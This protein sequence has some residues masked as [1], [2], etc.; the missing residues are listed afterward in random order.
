[1]MVGATW[2]VPAQA[3]SADAQRNFDIPAQPLPAALALFGRQSGLQVSV[4]AA[5]AE[6]RN[7][8]AVSGS[9]APVQALGRLLAGTG[10]TYR[11]SG[12]IVTLEPAPQR[13]EGT[14]LLDT[15]RVEGAN[16]D[17]GSAGGNHRVAG[18][19]GTAET[20]YVTP[21]SV[22]VVTRETLEAYPAQS[23]A[24]MLRGVTGVIS[25][26]ARTGGSLD[27]N[28]RG[29][30]GQGR[31]PVTVDGA[32]NGTT[33]YRGYQGTSNR[34][35]VDPDFISHIAIEKGPSMGNAIAGG[36]GG[37]VSMTTIAADDIVPEGETMAI[38]VKASLS[39]NS[40]TP[41]SEMTRTVM[42][43][44]AY[45]GD[46]Y[47]ATRGNDRPGVFTPTG[48]AGSLVF[49]SKG[50][51]LDIVAGYSF[52]RTGNYH[53]G[54]SGKYAPQEIGTPSEF[55]A[56][57]PADTQLLEMCQRAVA[58]YDRYGST[59]FVG[60]EE[61]YNTSTDSESVLVKATLRPADDHALELSYGGYWST[62]GENY[63][64]SLG[65]A[66]G[67]VFQTA[68]LS[69]TSLDRLAARYRWNPDS[70]LVDLRLNGWLSKMEEMAPSFGNFDPTRRYVDSWGA[71]LSN[72]SRVG[73]P[74]G[75]FSADYGA[76][77]L[78]EKAGPVEG[79][80]TGGS[81]P[82]GREGTRREIS[83]FT[84]TSLAPTDWLRID[85]GLRYQ[86]YKLQD[87]QTGT[88]YNTALLDRAEDA[89]S[90]SLGGVLTPVDGFQLFAS[91]KQAA[92][93]PSLMEATTGFFMLA[94]PDLHKEE[95]RNWEFGANYLHT[96]L[97]GDNDDLGLKLAWF[98]NDIDG[99]IARR[100]VTSSWAMQMYNIDRARFRGLEG[101][102]HYATG[103]FTMD[104]GATWYERIQFCRDEASGCIESSLASDY[105][106]N[107]IPPRWSAN[108]HVAQ[109]LL[110]DRASVGARI[111]YVGQ[112]AAGA[113][114]P[115]SGYMP[116]IS[117]IEWHP[118]LVAD[119]SGQFKLTPALSVD[120]SV[121]NLFDRY[122]NEAMSLGYVP[123]PGRTVRVGLT[124]T[125]GANGG[126]WPASWFGR[127]GNA[128]AVNWTGPYVGAD[129]GYGIGKLRGDVTDAAG[130][131]ADVVTDSRVSIDP[132]NAMGGLHAGFNYQTP[133]NIVL[134]V[135]AGLMGMDIGGSSSVIVNE[136]S[137]MTEYLQS[138]HKLESDTSYQWDRLISLRGKLGYSLGRTLVYAAAGIGWMRETDTR[139]QYRSTSSQHRGIGNDVE[140]Y[141]AETDRRT[142]SGVIVGGGLERA[143]G[144]HWS[145]RAEYSYAH[146]GDRTFRFD[147]AR[148]G[149]S[150]PYNDFDYGWNDDGSVW[151]D[152][153]DGPGTSTIANGRHV[154]SRGDLHMLSLGI[155]YRF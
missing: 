67:S 6:G 135:E 127:N 146:F 26:E 76:S 5:L 119:L 24:D 120:V 106:T 7:S 98:D 83:L 53:A 18:W 87:E 52:R 86:H 10:L 65:S 122:Y 43:P 27:L 23:P 47:L 78:H 4:A 143:V 71:D 96:G 54:D 50:D 81:L 136:E 139:N 109:K 73:T 36:I 111:N 70:A 154:R 128:D 95:A 88:I 153:V 46:S 33:V 107:Y 48:G 148:E 30:Q 3:Q 155:S 141:F 93:L 129:F 103:G 82:P 58:F 38:R 64:G 11:I 91:Y 90:F 77:Y 2:A 59:P 150:L 92:R 142:R 138:W 32:I 37:S 100:Y 125:I 19:D 62:F 144:A 49:A 152:Y 40:S 131:P 12:N 151:F 21:G 44:T 41:G 80:A 140:H 118:Y 121:D 134:G 102:L 89:F 66:T 124:G 39:T 115:Q 116:L 112:R 22:S 130:N 126:L 149:I 8:S 74:A 133:A 13:A 61:V 108:L 94:N 132:R 20:I 31:V 42:Q 113:E 51:V 114:K 60:G 72:S 75:L 79:W 68:F 117:A 9:M 28:I 97:L 147:Q 84:Q 45:Y 16:A 104:A 55:C 85:G 101:N 57:G 15:L 34:S 17:G 137:D 145:L 25:G 35:F 110:D 123:A 99:Y 1:M 14:I 63:P 29:L 69:Q 105:A 56:A